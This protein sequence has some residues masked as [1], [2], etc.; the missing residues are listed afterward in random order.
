MALIRDIHRRGNTIIVVTHEPDVANMTQRQILL[1]DGVV[2]TTHQA[3]L[4]HAQ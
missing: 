2:T 3:H 4:Q 1:R